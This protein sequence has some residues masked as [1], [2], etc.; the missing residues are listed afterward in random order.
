MSN[1]KSE[2][3]VIKTKD[4]TFSIYN[5]ELNETYHS[6]NGALQESLH[7]YIQNGFNQI[8]T[9]PVHILEIGLGTGLNAAL[10]ILEANKT[11]RNVVYEALEPYPLSKSIV[12]QFALGYPRDVSELLHKIAGIQE[13]VTYKISPNGVFNWH[14]TNIQTFNS[15]AKYDLIY[16]DAFAPEKQM[17][18]WTLDIFHKLYELLNPNGRLT[19]YCA[20]GIV[21]RMLKQAGFLVQAIPGPPGKR[22]MTIAL[23]QS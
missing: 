18:I 3:K 10:T 16:F 21:K 9:N 4:G 8:N 17:D 14:L 22:E 6:V 13:G 12:Q 19:T 15:I 7:V 5:S 2:L 1:N 20:K 23:K 11:K